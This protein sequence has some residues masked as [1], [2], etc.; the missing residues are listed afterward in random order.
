M[1]RG[2]HAGER[3]V[4]QR[5]G[6]RAEADRLAGMLDEP[7]LRSG[8]GQFLAERTFAGL[9]ARDTDGRLWIS[10]VTGTPGFLRPTSATTLRIG[11]QPAAGDPLHGLPADQ[12]AGLL[13]IE[14]ARRR[15][16]RINGTLTAA[17]PDGLTIAVEQAYGNCPQ[18]IQQ[19][20]L[21]PGTTARTSGPV[22][23]T[24]ALTPD[25][26]ALIAGADTLLLGT[27]HPDGGND[28]SH[29]G[30]PAG[31][32]RVVDEHRLWW[33]DYPGNNMFNSFGNLAVDPAA[34]LLFVDFAAGRAL[35]LSGSARVEWT[36]GPGDDGATG[37][38]VVFDLEAVV[39]GVP[40]PLR[41]GE[42]EPYRRNPALT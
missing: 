18:Y 10:P 27:T 24:A 28:A 6:T 8:L 11:T 35:H 9:A 5:A 1:E 20:V 32:V 39:A 21:A 19:R 4:Q 37:R 2:F 14:F 41:A 31:F 13:A 23:R 30:G 22:V 17:G 16:A 3:A 38:R 29:R 25:D 12:P 33:P 34:A 36:T 7:D 40:L 42:V 26:A 15:R